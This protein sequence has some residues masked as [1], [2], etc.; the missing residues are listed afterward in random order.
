MKVLDWVRGTLYGE[1]MLRTIFHTTRFDRRLNRGGYVHLRRWKVYG[2]YGLAHQTATIWLTAE[3]L[4]ITFR[5]QPLAHYTVSVSTD[6]KRLTDVREPQLIETEFRSPQLPLWALNDD[7]W[8]KVIPPKHLQPLT[9]WERGVDGSSRS[10]R[11]RRVGAKK[12]HLRSS[13]GTL[14]S[15]QTVSVRASELETPLIPGV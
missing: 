7:E 12:Q 11:S 4:T 3:N 10:C 1:E 2:E 5:D 6:Q 15:N 13:K 9:L 8:L 14:P